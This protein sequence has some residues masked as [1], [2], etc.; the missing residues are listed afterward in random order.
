MAYTFTKLANGNVDVLENG[1]SIYG[2]NTPGVSTAYAKSLGYTEPEQTFTTP[3]GAKV[4]AGGALVS[5][6]T[7]DITTPVPIV[8]SADAMK[9]PSTLFQSPATPTPPSYSSMIASVPTIESIASSKSPEQQ[10]A[11]KEKSTLETQL[12]D[13]LK[14]LGTKSTFQANRENEAGI[15]DLEKN[16]NDVNAQIAILQNEAKAIPIQLQQESVGRGRTEAGIAPIQEDRLRENAIKALTLSSIAETYR[17][18]LA[19]ATAQV[20]RAVAA[21]FDPKQAQ[22]DYLKAALQINAGRMSE[23]DREQAAIISA[24]LDERQKLLDEAKAKRQKTLDLVLQAGA[25][26]APASLLTTASGQDP[27]VAAATL[28]Q[29]LREKKDLMTVSPGQTVIDPATGKPIY[30]APPAPGSNVYN[31]S[32]SDLQQGAANAGMTLN[33]FSALAPDSQNWLINNFGVFKAQKDLVDKSQKTKEEVAKQIIAPDSV[34]PVQVQDVLL[35]L[36]GVSRA[37]A[38]TGAGGSGGGFWDSVKSTA[39]AVASWL[40]R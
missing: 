27:E 36:L 6:P 40:L 14:G 38:S 18:N 39:G 22:L 29:Y 24:K 37:S 10:K 21:E 32:K 7:V 34:V 1:K 17:G 23:A 20:A 33:A 16:L 9:N 4:T 28:Q 35:A 25:A 8:Y 19:T 30:T 15:P 26:G 31:F 3:S 11:E 5:G 13:V 12:L 2:A